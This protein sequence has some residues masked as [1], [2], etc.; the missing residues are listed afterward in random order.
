MLE[1]L[2]ERDFKLDELIPV[3]SKRSIGKSILFRGKEIAVVS[4]SDAVAL[5]PDIALFS[6]GSSVSKEW[7]PKFAENGTYVIDNSSAWRMEPG[8]PLVV[9]EVNS[10]DLQ[11]GKYIIAN[12]NCSTIQL[13]VALSPL[14]R[15]WG[16]KR[17]VISTYQSITGTG[18][19]AVLQYE[20]ERDGEPVDKVYPHPIFENCIPHCDVFLEDGYTREEMKLVHETRKILHAPE[21]AITA[22]AVRVPVLGGHSE[23]VNV[24]F[25]EITHL[26][27]IRRVL[28]KSHGIVVADNPEDA[29]YPMPLTAHEQ[30]HVYIGRLRIDA[31]LANAFNMWIVSDNLRK[32]AATNAVQIAEILLKKG[33]V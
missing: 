33:F 21:L 9:P 16:I 3:G 31:S 26:A 10:E 4:V 30:D 1:I 7:A 25:K 11:D 28:E 6:A 2:S 14:H 17:L 32:G 23:S 5:R 8:I 15:E 13:V 12:P 27:D 20:A 18:K 29:L 22:T 19:Q 24:E